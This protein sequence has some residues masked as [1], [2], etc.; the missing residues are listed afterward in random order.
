[1]NNE[2]DFT[3]KIVN[4]TIKILNE[5]GFHSLHVK[6]KQEAKNFI[7]YHVGVGTLVTLEEC[8]EIKDLG[9]EQAINEN[10]G[11][12]LKDESE[13][14][15]NNATSKNSII[16][17]QLHGGKYIFNNEDVITKNYDYSH[18]EK[19]NRVK[20][21]IVIALEYNTILT[22]A[23]NEFLKHLEHVKNKFENEIYANSQNEETI[24]NDI[25]IIF[26]D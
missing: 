22:D 21:I 2:N 17:V 13:I 11:T 9:I 26:I 10:G 7:M 12:I 16:K 20:T 25:S 6:S 18:T 4:N 1:M 19:C 5:L 24:Y 23:I 14:N 15:Y 8:S 3:N